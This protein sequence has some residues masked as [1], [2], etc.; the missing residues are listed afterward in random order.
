MP[1]SNSN[2][3]SLL[4]ALVTVSLNVGARPALAADGIDIVPWQGSR[5]DQA[6]P[7]SAL[8]F[9]T[10]TNAGATVT[11]PVGGEG[12]ELWGYAFGAWWLIDVL[13][14]GNTITL[15]SATQGAVMRIVKFGGFTKLA[16]AGVVSAGTVAYKFCPLETQ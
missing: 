16:I 2:L 6:T 13:H 5:Y 15:T 12:V 9:L 3:D 4:A 7:D 10:P 1:N 11:A 8:C 14:G